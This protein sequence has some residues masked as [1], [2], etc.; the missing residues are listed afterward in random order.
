[1]RV[2]YFY[3]ADVE[4]VNFRSINEEIRSRINNAVS[5]QTNEL[6]EELIPEEE[7]DRL[8][9]ESPLAVVMGNYFKVI[10]NLANG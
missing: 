8:K 9:V 6:I 3:G 7:V 4:R 1:M 5:S 10:L 2:N